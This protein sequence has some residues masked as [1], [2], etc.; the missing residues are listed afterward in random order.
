VANNENFSK[1]FENFSKSGFKDGKRRFTKEEK[2]V[3]IK[4][5]ETSRSTRRVDRRN[6]ALRSS[7]QARGNN[8]KSARLKRSRRKTLFY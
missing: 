4:R 7:S 2:F 5:F 8:E 6:S 1:N 3:K